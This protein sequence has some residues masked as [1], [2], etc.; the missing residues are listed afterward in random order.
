MALDFLKK[1]NL[2]LVMCPTCHSKNAFT[3]KCYVL[4]QSTENPLHNISCDQDDSMP[5]KIS[6]TMCKCVFVI[7]ELNIYA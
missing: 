1:C 4:D 6:R 3:K 2:T 5:S 7:L